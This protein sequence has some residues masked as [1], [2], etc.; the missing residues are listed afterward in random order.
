MTI[1][2]TAS[3]FIIKIPSSVGINEVQEFL[4]FLRYKEL[5]SKFKATQNDVEDLVGEVKSAW[6][7]K[8]AARKEA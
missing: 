7:E 8:R 4:D 5:T 6:K 3:E 2:R 1:E